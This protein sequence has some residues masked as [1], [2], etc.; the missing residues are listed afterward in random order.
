MKKQIMRNRAAARSSVAMGS[1]LEA[2]PVAALGR[3]RGG[4]GPEAPDLDPTPG[5]T[6]PIPPVVGGTSNS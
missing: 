3:V 1:T 4:G 5:Q 6:D 2:L